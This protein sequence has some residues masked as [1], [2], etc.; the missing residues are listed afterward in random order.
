MIVLIHIEC[1]SVSVYFIQYFNH[2]YKNFGIFLARMPD[3]DYA[4]NLY[5]A[6]FDLF[7]FRFATPRNKILKKICSTTLKSLE[8][9]S[10]RAKQRTT[11]AAKQYKR[12]MHRI[13]LFEKGSV[14][15]EIRNIPNQNAKLTRGKNCL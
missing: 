3:V 13:S 5:C 15:I 10:E 9:F 6:D 12:Y 7:Q 2:M 4:L 8:Y 1:T 14:F 11:P